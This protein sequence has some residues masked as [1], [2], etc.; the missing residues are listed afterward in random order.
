MDRI[1]EVKVGGNHLQKDNKNA[2]VRGEANV[3]KLRITF[4]E[5]WIPYTKKITFWNA[6]GLN[7]VVIDLLPHLAEGV[8][9]YLVP[10]PAE[11]MEEA[12]ALTFVIEGT[13]D[14]KVQRSLSDRLDV[15]DAPVA[16]NAG[17]PVPPT[18]DELTQLGGEIEKI[19]SD[20]LDAVAAKNEAKSY[21]DEV[22]EAE[23][24]TLNYMSETESYKEEAEQSAMKAENAV[25]KT[26]YIGDN[27]NWFA[28]DSV[29]GAF[30]DTGVKAQAGS[31][32]Y[33]GDNPPDNADVWVNPD[34]ES[35]IY[36]P[37]I[38]ANG[39][40]YTFNPE[41]QTFADSGYSAEGRQGEQGEQGEQ[42]YTPRRGVDYWN[43]DDKAEIDGYIVE[44]TKIIKADVEGIQAQINEEAHFR[45]YFS[46]NAKIQALE[47][48][49]NDFAYSAESGTRWI[50]EAVDGWKDTGS[51]VPDQL[52]PAS[53]TL[54]LINGTASKGSENAYARGDH[55]HP[56][57]TTRLGVAEF[58]E[59]K[60]EL[61]NSLDNII[62]KY[63][64][65]GDVE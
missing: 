8:N 55:R 43:D 47:A 30:Y 48:T 53:D 60:I 52:T 38:G 57:D 4:D 27:G 33:C 28:W 26:S 5:S 58:N 39:N 65:D 3:A 42:G 23:K 41:T 15:K 12:G 35:S 37:F 50:Y 59:F 44:Q 36:A 25:G 21:R 32:V 2:G 9:T 10:I 24:N 64:L 29:E 40:W 56:T 51:H 19:K 61:E 11:P 45:G 49:P 62:T 7:P 17:Q 1:I 34:G 14:D 46:T 6:R 20:I 16:Q 54:P 18:P 22:K 63:G 31:T 13:V